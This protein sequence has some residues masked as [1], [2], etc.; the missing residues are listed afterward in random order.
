MSFGTFLLAQ[1]TVLLWSGEVYLIEAYLIDFTGD[2]Y[3]KSVT[4]S[5]LRYLR[6][7]IKFTGLDSL[8]QLMEADKAQAK[9][10]LGIE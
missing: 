8:I 5:F 2:L 7:E 4:V 1:D 10:I 3:G 9:N 6:E